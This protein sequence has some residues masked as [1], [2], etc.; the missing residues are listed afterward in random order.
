VDFVVDQSKDT[1][2]FCFQEIMS[3]TSEVKIV[4]ELFANEDLLR[5]ILLHH[6]V[7]MRVTAA[8]A[9]DLDYWILIETEAWDTIRVRTT[10]DM[11]MIDNATVI[12]ADMI[13][14]NGFVH[15]IDKVLLPPSFLEANGMM[16]DRGDMDIAE[17]AMGNDMFTTLVAWVQAADW[18]DMLMTEWPWTI[19]APTNEAFTKLLNENNMT[20]AELLADTELLKSVLSYHVVPWFYTSA[21]IM[22][23]NGNV[24]RQTENGASLD[25]GP[26]GTVR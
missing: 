14:D 19:F 10:E 1:D 20:A 15:V 6:V 7:D 24:M 5:T 8:D 2:V 22:A 25:I 21:D 16:T 13:A 11:L 26:T 9:M 17:I 18:A 3:T 12:E 23:L 4:D